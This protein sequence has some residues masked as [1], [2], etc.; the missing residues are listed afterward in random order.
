[1]RLRYQ[2]QDGDGRDVELSDKPLTIGRSADA[3]VLVLDEKASRVHCGIRFSDGAFYIKDLKSKNGTFVNDKQVD[4]HQ[5]RA[6][7]RIRIGST[8]FM[9]EQEGMGPDTAIQEVQDKLD[10]G[11]GYGTILREIVHETA[12]AKPVVAE[13][14]E[15]TESEPTE[16]TVTD[17]PVEV[18][19]DVE[20]PAEPAPEE[21]ST[22][23]K[24]K[25]A[26]RAPKKAKATAVKKSAG[27]GKK[28]VVK[29]K[30][31]KIKKRKPP[32]EP[33]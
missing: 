7:D 16:Q 19:A 14:V 26:A 20:E 13:V 12:D 3:D 9:F 1:M 4:L 18:E 29:K 6:G 33:D 24:K 23:K 17:A 2:K 10:D 28:F 21:A 15:I 30:A 32:A 22:A 27:A 25:A 11:H 31:V 5:L 8:T